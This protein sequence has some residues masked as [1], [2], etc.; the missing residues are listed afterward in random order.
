MGFGAIL[1]PV[2]QAVHAEIGPIC[3]IDLYWIP[4]PDELVHIAL[5]FHSTVLSK[6]QLDPTFSAAFTALGP[7]P[8]HLTPLQ[9][10][11]SSYQFY[12][13]N[14]I[15]GFGAGLS[16]IQKSFGFDDSCS[17][18]NTL[19]INWNP[20]M[21]LFAYSMVDGNVSS[22]CQLLTNDE[23]ILCFELMA[24][25]KRVNLKLPSSLVATIPKI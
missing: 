22:V 5:S 18:Q 7:Y 3:N 12:G 11:N 23:F 17:T 14:P 2:F 20:F 19:T 1:T 21:S 6:I 10:K 24:M 16:F 8:L 4:I 9:W 25:L 15:C 13:G